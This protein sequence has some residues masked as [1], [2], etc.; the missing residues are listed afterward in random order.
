MNLQELLNTSKFT[1]F[2]VTADSPQEYG[3]S[4]KIGDRTINFG[5]A[6]ERVPFEEE[7]FWEIDFTE[8]NADKHQSHEKTGSGREFEV[9]AFIKKCLENLIKKHDPYM[10][11]FSAVKR[12]AGDARAKLY[13]RMIKNY[14]TGYKL[15][16]IE[17]DSGALFVLT[18]KGKK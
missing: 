14:L 18:K 3:A 2:K 6:K 16:K 4:A 11:K 15:D 7:Y 10:L 13:E 12:D 1:D 5:A 17:G 8:E 9:F